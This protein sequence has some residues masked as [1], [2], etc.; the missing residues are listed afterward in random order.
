MLKVIKSTWSFFLL[1]L[2]TYLLLEIFLRC[3]GYSPINPSQNEEKIKCTPPPLF[4]FHPDY[5]YVYEP[6]NKKVTLN[7]SLS[8]TL[9]VNEAGFR[10]NPHAVCS[11]QRASIAVFGCSFFGGMG[12][13]DDE[14]V[15]AH[16]QRLVGD[17]CV[18]NYAIPGHGMNMQLLKLQ[19][20]I[21]NEQKPEIA[22]F[23]LA[24][25]HLIRNPG[26]F[27]FV[28]NFADIRDRPSYYLCSELSGD[29]KL[30]FFLKDINENLCFLDYWSAAYHLLKVKFYANQFK[31]EYLLDLENSLI[32]EAYSI[33]NDYGVVPVFMLITKDDLSSSIG[34]FL[35]SKNIPFIISSV[36][37]QSDE[38]N[39]NPHD[40]HPNAFAHERYALEIFDFIKNDQFR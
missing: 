3:Y 11:P 40:Q 16:L 14:V 6:G 20:L 13:N 32:Q 2:T 36:D 9:N 24:S 5:G 15:S 18:Y 33:C 19:D 35:E 31:D 8:Y 1:F 25:F 37:Y 17:T 4:Q 10:T 34:N 30:N 27:N 7:R 23:E 39:L 38:F 26:G 22:V 21:E 12:V 29:D 28:K